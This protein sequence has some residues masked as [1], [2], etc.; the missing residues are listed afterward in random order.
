MDGIRIAATGDG[1]AATGDGIAATGDGIAATG[2]GIAATGDGIRIA[3]TGDGMDGIAATGDGMDR[4]A[5][6]APFRLTL[7]LPVLPQTH[8]PLPSHSCF[9]L[10]TEQL[11]P[12]NISLIE[13]T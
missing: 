12:P 10:M 2:D 1:I 11:L 13:F 9:S 8:S 5:A 6:A 7:H 4:I 3:A